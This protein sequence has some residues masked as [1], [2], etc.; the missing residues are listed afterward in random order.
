MH[1]VRPELVCGERILQCVGIA[2]PVLGRCN[3]EST[4]DGQTQCMDPQSTRHFF[5]L[6]I[7]F[8]E[9]LFCCVPKLVVLYLQF[10]HARFSQRHC[11][12]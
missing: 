7:D 6:L 11:V 1:L 2:V 9:M 3:T 8:S 4:C 5:L 12:H 10:C